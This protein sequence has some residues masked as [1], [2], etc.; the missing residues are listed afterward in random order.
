MLSGSAPAAVGLDRAASSES[1]CTTTSVTV[2][3]WSATSSTRGRRSR[4]VRITLARDNRRVCSRK[5]P[6][7]AAFTAALTAPMRAAPSQK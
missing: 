2:S 4:S 6:L 1:S 7:F 3:N 5:S